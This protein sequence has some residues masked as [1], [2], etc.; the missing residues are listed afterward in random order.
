MSILC[1]S[2]GK[3]QTIVPKKIVNNGQRNYYYY[4]RTKIS[5]KSILTLGLILGNGFELKQNLQ[6]NGKELEQWLIAFNDLNYLL[7]SSNSF[8]N[9]SKCSFSKSLISFGKNTSS[10]TIKTKI[11]SITSQ[12]E[13]KGTYQVKESDRHCWKHCF[14]SLSMI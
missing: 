7:N 14:V 2:S 1:S 9:S 6:N 11:S 10:V 5:F 4:F 12:N 13:T 3:E 8:S